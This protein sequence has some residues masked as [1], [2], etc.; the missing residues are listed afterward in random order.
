MSPARYPTLASLR[1]VIGG[2][3]ALLIAAAVAVSPLLPWPQIT[4]TPA[5]TE[6][7]V[8]TPERVAVCT[9]ALLAVGRDSTDAD[10]LSVAAPQAVTVGGDSAPSDSVLRSDATTSAPTVWTSIAGATGS[11]SAFAAAGAVSI[12]DADLVG[13]ASSACQ[14]PLM[15]SWLVAGSGATGASDLVIISNPGEV[16][17]TVDLTVYGAGGATAP[18]GGTDIIVAP[19]AQRVI[20]LAGIA[21]G[22]ESP[23]VHVQA[24]GAPVAASLQS[25][26]TRTLEPGGIDQSGMLASPDGQLTI[27]GVAVTVDGLTASAGEAPT[28]V[29]I[30]APTTAGAATI[31]AYAVGETTPA[32]DPITVELA[33]GI[34]AVVEVPDLPVGSYVIEVTAPV[35]IAASVWQTTGFGAGADFAWYLPSPL[36]GAESVISVPAGPS[37]RLTL[38]NPGQTDA[39]VE[40]TSELTGPVSVT[41]PAGSSAQLSVSASTVYHLSGDSVAAAVGFA[42][43]SSLGSFPVWATD[44]GAEPI[45]VYP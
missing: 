26:I 6:V 39:S 45:V 4:A 11:A 3:L 15:D 9:G 12:S 32:R 1:P 33:A 43:D 34:P 29:R 14:T 37:P 38:M 41:I 23:V 10:G 22:E 2:A 19:G 24:T 25:S 30:L 31:T 18:P 36:L 5:H 16:A 13:Y 21:L 44:A 40:L 27:G 20:A 28:Q 7:A 8:D 42:G 35:V 17:A